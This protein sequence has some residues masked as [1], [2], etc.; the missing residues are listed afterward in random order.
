MKKIVLFFL[1]VISAGLRAQSLTAYTDQ[2]GYL[3]VFDNGNTTTLEY[4]MP[5][6]FQVGG[7]CIAY[8]DFNSNFKV[9]YKGDVT[10]L[11]NGP[12]NSYKVTHNLLMYVIAGQLRVFDRGKT[13]VLSVNAGSYS[14]GDSLVGF[15][16][17]TYQAFYVYYDHDLFT[18]ESN[19]I[20]NPLVSF[21]ASNNTL[22]FINNQREF[23]IFW[24]G[25]A[26]KVFTL[27]PGMDLDYQTGSN[28]VAFL[29]GPSNSLAVFYK[30][31]TYNVST[32]PV[33]SY[34]T[35][36]E[37]VAYED[38]NGLHAFYA[39]KNYDLCSSSNFSYDIS[40]SM[41]IYYTPGYFRAF[42]RGKITVLGNYMPDEYVL[43]NN[44]LAWVNQQ[45]GLNAFYNDNTYDLSGFDR[46]I[47]KLEGNT[48]WF[49][50]QTSSNKVF[51]CGKTY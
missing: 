8:L 15:Y 6:S 19:T 46:V 41:L 39:G 45:G 40:D 49:K 26:Q 21:Q 4:Q 13:K 50:S 36:D 18:L 2:R 1:L 23:K 28:I 14:V 20:N 27:S 25:G 22:A 29:A 32:L 3:N 16:D 35:A 42:N 47:F 5:Q 7:A 38:Q 37:M 24:N 11:Y 30:G 10:T 43:D 31:N 33:K 48:L 44:T 9:Y 12:V 17:N 51:L 34:K